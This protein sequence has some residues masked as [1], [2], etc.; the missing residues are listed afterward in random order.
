[1][2]SN[3]RIVA[4][5][6]GLGLT[7][8]SAARAQGASA[9]AAGGPAPTKVGIVGIQE[10]IGA[11]NEGKK[12]MEALQKRFAPKQGEL[13][14]LND[15][16]ENL[17]KQYQAQE[18]KLSD[19]QK[20]SRAKVIEA[21]SKSLQRSAED[22]QNEVQQAEQD[23]LNRL[24]GKMLAV[25]EKYAAANGYGLILDVSN[26]QTTPVLW[27]SE[28]TNITQALVDAY[29]AQSP[30]AAP[31]RPAGSPGAAASRPATPRPAGTVPQKKP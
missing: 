18:A 13:K 25:M 4:L 10:A 6:L 1:M 28:T 15:E 11:T 9:P 16:V 2:L 19:E 21:K 31:A 22:F 12:E 17:K 20:G 29:N 26:P 24:G 23:V 8:S 27:A 3:T 14:A 5:A 7:A 30:V